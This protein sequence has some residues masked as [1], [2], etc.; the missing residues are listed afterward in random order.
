MR[1]QSSDIKKTGGF[2][3]G[4]E[5]VN[6]DNTVAM[7]ERNEG[8]MYL[9]KEQIKWSPGEELAEERQLSPMNDE[10]EEEWNENKKPTANT[11]QSQIKYVLAILCCLC[12]HVL[13]GLLAPFSRYLQKNAQMP[14]LL[15]IF[16]SYLMALSVYSP[17]LAYLLGRCLW[18]FIFSRYQ[19]W[20]QI[21]VQPISEQPVVRSWKEKQIHKGY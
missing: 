13:F 19:S 20:N 7:H 1:L 11:Q 15:L 10:N 3:M 16:S 21:D 12:A 8:D 9:E 5:H 2:M 17:R 18:R 4:R 6:G 14:S